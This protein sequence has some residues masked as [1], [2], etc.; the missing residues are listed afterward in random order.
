MAKLRID[1]LPSAL[2]DLD[3]ATDYLADKNL[4]A[5]LNLLDDVDR[6]F[7]QLSEFPESGQLPK[8]ERLRREGYRILVMEYDYL[9]FYKVIDGSVFI[10]RLI[11]GRRN[12]GAIL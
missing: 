10:H 3:D 12:Y 9:M 1:V 8:D 11:D 7:V 6:G 4:D 2:A 5:A